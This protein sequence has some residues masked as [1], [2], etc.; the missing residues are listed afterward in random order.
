MPFHSTASS[1]LSSKSVRDAH[2]L[3]AGLVRG[4]AKCG[5]SF[6]RVGVAAL[7]QGQAAAGGG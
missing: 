3:T 4:S 1:E 2:A 7:R 5:S 6:L